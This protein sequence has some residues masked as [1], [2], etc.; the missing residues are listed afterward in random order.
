MA[1]TS[2]YGLLYVY[3]YSSFHLLISFYFCLFVLLALVDVMRP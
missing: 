2:E 1:A 3:F